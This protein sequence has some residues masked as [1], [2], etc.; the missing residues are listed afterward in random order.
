MVASDIRDLEVLAQHLRLIYR[1]EVRVVAI[2]AT[3]VESCIDRIGDAATSLGEIDSLYFPIGVSQPDDRGLLNLKETVA[4]LDTNLTV[5]IGIVSRF[6]PQF[7]ERGDGHIVAFGSI[8]AVRGRRAN[9]VYS[10][11]KRGLESYF[12]SIRHLTS[13]RGVIVQFYRLG[14]VAT[15]QSFGQRLLFPAASPQSVVRIVLKN[16][17]K[18]I[19]RQFIPG[20]W[21][22]IA[23]IVSKIPWT[24][25]RK[26]NF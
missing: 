10:A 18:D 25:F 20:Y 1:V 5:V 13:G 24:I 4:I 7:L 15:R 22:L 19:G 8:A 9:I 2:D 16:H 23:F 6:L 11:A 21:V 26:L 14:Y 17:R 3:C 12:E